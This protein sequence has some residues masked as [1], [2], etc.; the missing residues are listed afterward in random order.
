MANRKLRETFEVILGAQRVT[1]QPAAAAA[2]AVAAQ[3]DAAT[4]PA[5]EPSA[6]P[7]PP[8]IPSAELDRYVALAEGGFFFPNFISDF[9]LRDLSLGE[10]SVFNRLLRLTQGL[11]G[12]A[13]N[14]RIRDVAD[15]CGITPEFAARAVESLQEKKLLNAV[16]LH[17]FSRSIRY[18]LDVLKQWQGKLVLCA[19]CHGP[20]RP[21]EEKA[22]VAVARSAQGTQEVPVHRR[23]L[24]GEPLAEDGAGGRAA[25]ADG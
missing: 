23:C 14:L 3:P 19:V 20:I 15:A 4:R 6:A 2:P 7:R 12:P 1:G 24:R 10:Q 25:R 16:R 22:L 9:L 17:P 11:D 21:G 13:G 18:R 8:V 5:A